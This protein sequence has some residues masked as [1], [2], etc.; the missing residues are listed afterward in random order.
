MKQEQRKIKLNRK[1]QLA[2]KGIYNYNRRIST[3]Q[4]PKPI[5]RTKCECSSSN[6][7]EESFVSDSSDEN[8]ESMLL[9]SGEE[10]Y[11]LDE[12]SL[13]DAKSAYISISGPSRLQKFCDEP[14]TGDFVLVI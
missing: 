5:R 8:L 2:Y 6:E 14:K 11:L 4:K 9:S 10:E 3:N 13:P 1:Q 12:E 7:S